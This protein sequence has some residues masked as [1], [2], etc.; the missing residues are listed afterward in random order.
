MRVWIRIYARFDV[1]LIGLMNMNL[2]LA[3]MMRDA[4]TAYAHGERIAYYIDEP[5]FY[6]VSVNKSARFSFLVPDSDIKTCYMLKNLKPRCRNMFVKAVFRNSLVQQNLT[7]FFE[8]ADA[9]IISNHFNNANVMPQNVRCSTLKVDKTQQ[10]EFAGN[11]ITV[12]RSVHQPKK[13]NVQPETSPY[14]GYPGNVCT[15]PLQTAYSPVNVYQPT[16]VNPVVSG[17]NPVNVVSQITPPPVQQPVQ[18]MQPPVQPVQQVQQSVQKAQPFT[19]VSSPAASQVN[20]TQQPGV[21][22][23]V[24]ASVPE[25]TEYEE[26]SDYLTN[27]GSV[28]ETTPENQAFDDEMLNMFDNL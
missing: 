18:Q 2:P 10:I 26:S 17:N 28:T 27:T 13:K 15:P 25:Y 16:S 14:L 22:P 11:T 3:D 20:P 9:G 7:C 12:D 4:V 5:T 21:T 1:D 24:V 8:N 6:D 19:D 23:S